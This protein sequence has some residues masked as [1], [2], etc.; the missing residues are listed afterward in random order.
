MWSQHTTL[1]KHTTFQASSSGKGG[2]PFHLGRF[3]FPSCP[4]RDIDLDSW[5]GEWAGDKWCSGHLPP[6][7]AL[8]SLSILPVFSGCLGW[9]RLHLR[10]RFH[11]LAGE[12]VGPALSRTL[13]EEE[14]EITQGFKTWNGEKEVSAEESPQSQTAHLAH[15]GQ[16]GWQHLEAF[17]W[18]HLT[19]DSLGSLWE[20][21]H[22]CL[23]TASLLCSPL[24]LS[25]PTN[26][27]F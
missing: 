6:S 17:P 19:G 15:K 12:S 26:K 8:Q 20:A 11:A 22:C 21:G 7:E 25:I 23:S 2:R 24:Q 9:A 27:T 1:W 18:H 16:A 14:K 10:R 3:H 5:E 4:V 13:N